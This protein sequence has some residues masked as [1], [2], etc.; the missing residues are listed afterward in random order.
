MQYLLQTCPATLTLLRLW[1]SI[2]LP[3]QT[4]WSYCV[5]IVFQHS[6][7]S[8]D[9]LRKVISAI[10]V[11]WHRCLVTH[12]NFA[13]ETIHFLRCRWIHRKLEKRVRW[14]DER[15]RSTLVTIINLRVN[16]IDQLREITTRWCYCCLLR[17]F[18]C[19][20]ILHP[21]RQWTRSNTLLGSA[22]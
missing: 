10:Q 14:I 11:G 5:G 2:A 8:C 1:R 22:Q 21:H 17:G 13:S 9:L 4:R 3:P 18:Q 19:I 6:H 7:H 12:S 16:C 15:N 20:S